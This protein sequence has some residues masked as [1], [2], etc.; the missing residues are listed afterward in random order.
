VSY[1][2]CPICL[3][4][5]GTFTQFTKAEGGSVKRCADLL[6]LNFSSIYCLIAGFLYPLL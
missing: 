5:S 2:S 1:R 6:V 4:D 3:T